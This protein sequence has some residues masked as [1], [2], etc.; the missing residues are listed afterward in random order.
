MKT[1]LGNPISRQL[2]KWVSVRN[3]NGS[4]LDLAL[5]NYADERTRAGLKDKFACKVIELAIDRGAAS[6]GVPKKEIKEALKH[7][8]IRRGLA[9][10]FE[11]I[12][13]YGIQRPQTTAAPF[14][15]VWDFTKQCNL[16]CKHCYENAGAKPADDELTTKEAK[17]IIDQFADIGVVAL[18]FSGGEPLM[19]ED[20]FE[21][22]EYAAKKEF[23]VSVASNGTLITPSVAKKLKDI[24]VAYIEVSLD[25]FEKEHDRFRRV[26]GSWKKTCQGI[27]NCVAAGLDMC[28]ATTVTHHNLKTI[29]KLLEFVERELKA[30]RFIAFNYIPTRRGKGIA[31][32]DITPEERENLLKFLYSKLIDKGCSLDIFSTAPQYARVAME[33]DATSIPAHFVNRDTVQLLKGRADNLSEFIGGCGA[34]RLY[35]ALEPNGDVQPCVF[36][37]IKVGNLR[38]KNLKEIWEDSPVLKQLRNR[39]E[40]KGCGNC[41]YKYLC[42]GCRARAYGYSGDLRGPDPGCIINSEEADKEWKDV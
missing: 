2:L 27:R 5:K 21:V 41:K 32:T 31:K 17:S 20:F 7:P 14:L 36:I 19:R 11:G 18:A 22:A 39:D 38:E 42:G 10:V 35:C 4:R 13:R 26:P 28:V 16:K 23:Y 40:Y 30:N 24:G 9:N 33:F 8:I 29:P 37:P 3:E 1:W 34:G 12:A 6:F 15:V 25:G